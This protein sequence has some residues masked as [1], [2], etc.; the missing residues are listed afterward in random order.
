MKTK[1]TR[2]PRKKYEQKFFF[3][4]DQETADRL[5]DFVQ[6]E[7]TTVSAYVRKIMSKHVDNLYDDNKG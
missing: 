4:L 5:L 2:T 1:K 7:K 3:T 6:M